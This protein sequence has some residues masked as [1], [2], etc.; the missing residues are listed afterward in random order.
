ML[1]SKAAMELQMK[2]LFRVPYRFLVQRAAEM[3][4]RRLNRQNWRQEASEGC[5]YL[6]DDQSD[7]GGSEILSKKTCFKIT[8]AVGSNICQP[9]EFLVGAK[10]MRGETGRFLEDH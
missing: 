1:E 4:R 3:S 5:S 9:H 2:A 7:E 8:L 6:E 10:Y